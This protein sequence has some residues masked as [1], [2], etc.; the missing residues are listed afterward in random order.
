MQQLRFYSSQWLLLIYMFRAT[1]S[2]IIRSTYA[3]YGHR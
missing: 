1:V 2:P 3:V